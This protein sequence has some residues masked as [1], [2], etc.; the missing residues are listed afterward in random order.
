MSEIN[1]FRFWTGLNRFIKR[2][3]IGHGIQGKSLENNHGFWGSFRWPR[4][5][6]FWEGPHMKWSKGLT[7]FGTPIF[8][9]SWCSSSYKQIAMG[10]LESQTMR[11]PSRVCPDAWGPLWNTS[12]E[13][14][15]HLGGK[16]AHTFVSP[17]RNIE[18]VGMHRSHDVQS[19]ALQLRWHVTVSFP[20]GSQLNWEKEECT[21]WGCG[22]PATL[23]PSACQ[24][25]LVPRCDSLYNLS[26]SL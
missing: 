22:S 23:E 1:T 20:L 5:L 9:F 4:V 8:L 6:R 11:S 26:D 10:L 13:E 25:L 2:L 15:W 18:N 16:L 14:F 3:T 19:P 21:H 7:K 24:P 12:S 17:W